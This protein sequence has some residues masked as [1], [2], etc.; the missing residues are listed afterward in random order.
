[1]KRLADYLPLVIIALLLV[2]AFGGGGTLLAKVDKVV[3]VDETSQGGMEPYISEAFAKLNE[4]D[5]ETRYTDPDVRTGTGDIPEDVKPAIE[6]ANS[7]GLPA[8]VVL[9]GETVLKVLD[10]PKTAESICEEVE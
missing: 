3:I 4:Q 6:A 8:M 10:L 2:A 1:M 5:I 7:H 9:S